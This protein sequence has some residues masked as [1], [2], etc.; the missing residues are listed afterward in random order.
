[1]SWNLFLQTDLD[2][3][4][5]SWKSHNIRLLN[6]NRVKPDVMYFVPELTNGYDTCGIFTVKKR[7]VSVQNLKYCK[8]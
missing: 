4:A 2:R 3:I 7:K 8:H 5:Q 6:C 1:M